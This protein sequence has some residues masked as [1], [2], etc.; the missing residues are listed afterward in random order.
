MLRYGIPAY[1]LPVEV[2]DKE[3]GDILAL[4]IDFR[5]GTALGEQTTIEQLQAEHDAVL[6][7]WEPRSAERSSSKAP[8][9]PTCSGAWSISP[10]CAPAARWP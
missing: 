10:T 7:P 5:P 3:I 4:G 1:R 2:L 6:L 8:T 9:I